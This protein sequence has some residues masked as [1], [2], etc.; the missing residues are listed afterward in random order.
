MQDDKSALA[1]V[2]MVVVWSLLI[3]FIGARIYQSM[4]EPGSP[5]DLNPKSFDEVMDGNR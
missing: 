3:A 5:F 2:F 1:A 4:T